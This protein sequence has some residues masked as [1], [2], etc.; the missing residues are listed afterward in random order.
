MKKLWFIRPGLSKKV[1][2][3][4]KRQLGPSI[5]FDYQLFLPK[6]NNAGKAVK[7]VITMIG[8]QDGIEYQIDSRNFV[9]LCPPS[10]ARYNDGFEEKTV[11]GT[12]MTKDEAKEA[13]KEYIE[14]LKRWLDEQ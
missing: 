3:E 13:V 7:P 14:K 1:Q 10:W 5:P 2:A 11:T 6:N 4:I 12:V 9:L 8:I